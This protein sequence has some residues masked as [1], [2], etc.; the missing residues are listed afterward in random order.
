MILDREQQHAS[1]ELCQRIADLGAPL[2]TVSAW[3]RWPGILPE[4]PPW[5]DWRIESVDSPPPVGELIPAYS[6]AELLAMC[7]A[8]TWLARYDHIDGADGL[9]YEASASH[10]MT[11]LR[12]N[13]ATAADALASLW[14][15][16]NTQPTPTEVDH[17]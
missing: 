12:A 3:W 9:E 1:P 4:S 17:E 13:G 2:S 5:I 7:P 14:L 16:L 11:P 8:G 10:M 6:V 15:A